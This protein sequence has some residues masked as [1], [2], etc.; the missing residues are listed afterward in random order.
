MNLRVKY[1]N[2]QSWLGISRRHC[3]EVIFLKKC[4]LLNY[5]RLTQSH[6][7]KE[8]YGRHFLA[9][10]YFIFIYSFLFFFFFFFFEKEQHDRDF[11]VNFAKLFAAV[12]F[13]HS[14]IKNVR[15]LS[16]KH[17]CSLQAKN[18]TTLAKMAL[19]LWVADNIRWLLGRSMRN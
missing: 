6:T 19:I 7:K 15:E 5:N 8:L 13:I 3:L 11:P 14:L 9:N 12:S 18:K 17:F 10:L 1:F 4:V 2:Q 16:S